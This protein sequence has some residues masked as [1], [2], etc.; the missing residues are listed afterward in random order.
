M[1]HPRLKPSGRDVFYHTYNRVAG[2]PGDRPFAEVEKEHFVSLLHKL[3]Q[4]YIVEVVGYTVMS[5]HFH[6]VLFAPAEPPS[7]EETCARYNAYYG[8]QPAL[9]PGTES[10]RAAA[11][12]L[13]DI[14]WFM[15]DLQHQFSC[16]FNRTRPIRRRGALWAGRFKHTLLEEGVAVWDCWQYIALNPVRAGLVADPADYRFS[17]FGAWCGSKRHPFAA[18]LEA[19]IMPCFKGLLHVADQSALHK[20]FREAF[21]WQMNRRQPQDVAEA[22]VKAAGKPLPFST[23]ATRRMRYWADGLVIGSRRFVTEIMSAAR[24]AEHLGKRRFAVAQDAALAGVELVCY[25]RLRNLTL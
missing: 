23:V 16:W 5:N 8:K 13:R 12:Q 15:H 1:R 19:H 10:C 2:E 4:L 7:E 14:S 21:A 25:K 18:N 20:R 17:D 6:L 3:S 9:Q 22:A 24:G 11:E